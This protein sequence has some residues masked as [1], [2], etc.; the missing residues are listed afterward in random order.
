MQR[1]PPE[2]GPRGTAAH[3]LPSVGQVTPMSR[4]RLQ[5]K[6]LK[7]IGGFCMRI[8]HALHVGGVFRF[9]DPRSRLTLFVDDV[10]AVR[11]A[12]L[13]GLRRLG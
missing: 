12:R 11:W 9:I 5:R 1:V 2:R 4:A 8:P 13:A 6:A 7:K 10:R 3:M